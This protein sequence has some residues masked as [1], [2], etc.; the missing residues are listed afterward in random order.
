MIVAICMSPLGSTCSGVQY[1]PRRM[2]D[3]GQLKTILGMYMCI[4]CIASLYLCW[5]LLI[6]CP[7]IKP[8]MMDLLTA[9]L[10]CWFSCWDPSVSRNVKGPAA[11]IYTYLLSLQDLWFQQQQLKGYNQQT[12]LVNGQNDFCTHT[13]I[14]MYMRD[15]E[16][17]QPLA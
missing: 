5:N 8:M 14:C 15:F 7:A 9:V 10:P 11:Y 16:R 6:A 2:Q 17:L 4:T 13:Y 1:D 3:A 12:G